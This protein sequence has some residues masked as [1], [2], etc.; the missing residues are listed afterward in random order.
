MEDEDGRHDGLL[1][2][3]CHT[4]MLADLD[5]IFHRGYEILFQRVEAL[6]H[7]RF[8]IFYLDAVLRD[9]VSILGDRSSILSDRMSIFFNF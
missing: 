6:I 5:R 2:Q 4:D 7:F 9:R 3:H 1:I 8:Q